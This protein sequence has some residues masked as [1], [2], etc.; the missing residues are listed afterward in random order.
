MCAGVVCCEAFSQAA[1]ICFDALWRT[2]KRGWWGKGGGRRAPLLGGDR[3]RH[4][5]RVMECTAL[6]A[7]R[8]CGV[9]AA[10]HDRRGRCGGH[11]SPLA[12]P[13]AV[14][15]Y[16]GD[17]RAKLRKARARRPNTARCGVSNRRPAAKTPQYAGRPAW[18]GVGSRSIPDA[19]LHKCGPPP[20]ILRGQLWPSLP[21]K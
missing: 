5:H 16:G 4:P 10:L 15:R 9:H 1:G 6:R 11:S 7:I 17:G 21:P 8:Q 3:A 12:R 20:N 13:S 18:W 2:A 19:A 14:R